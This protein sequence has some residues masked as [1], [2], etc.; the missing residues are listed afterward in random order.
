MIGLSSLLV[1]SS[2][3]ANQLRWI[4]GVALNNVDTFSIFTKNVLANDWIWPEYYPYTS[5]EIRSWNT[6]FPAHITELKGH[7]A[8]IVTLQ[9]VDRL[10][11]QLANE[12]PSE[13]EGYWE[14]SLLEL[15][16][17]LSFVEQTPK[18]IGV[19][20]GHKNERWSLIKDGYVRLNE[21]TCHLEKIHPYSAAY[22]V[23]RDRLNPG[24]GIIVLTTHLY[25]A[26]P[27]IRSHQV[28]LLLRLVHQLRLDYPDY[29]LLWSGD[30]NMRPQD[31]AYKIIVRSP[32]IFQNQFW[33]EVQS[34]TIRGPNPDFNWNEARDELLTGSLSDINAK[35][36][37]AECEF[38]TT[39]RTGT[40]DGILDYIFAIS[41]SNG[42]NVQLVGYKDLPSDEDVKPMPNAENPSDHLAL[43]AVLQ[44]NN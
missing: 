38:A 18:H 23:L 19:L 25:F 10:N 17:G 8:D 22:N 29:P 21:A 34:S 33:E 43:F 35:D 11:A 3:A 42:Q 12:S 1:F 36:L 30:F 14:P 9:E 4:D 40:F 32:E 24:R 7:N 2:I 27:A 20:V 37:F 15:G 5:P 13:L 28:I 31:C 16:Y 39:H 44:Y 26:S 41:A 6:R